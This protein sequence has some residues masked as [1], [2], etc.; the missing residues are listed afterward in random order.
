MEEA[1]EELDEAFEVVKYIHMGHRYFGLFFK[2]ALPIA[3]LSMSSIPTSI[4]LL[5]YIR[6]YVQF[7]WYKWNL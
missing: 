4:F 6:G 2:D 7:A 1:L 3:S 5:C